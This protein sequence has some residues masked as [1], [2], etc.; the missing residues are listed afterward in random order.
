MVS[1]TTE[2]DVS[3]KPIPFTTILAVAFGFTFLILVRWQVDSVLP[4]LESFPIHSGNIGI[5]EVLLL[6][7]VQ[8]FTEWLPISSSGHLVI[9]QSLLD[10]RV[11]V[12]FDVMLHL[13]SLLSIIILLKDDLVA[14]IKP[15]MSLDFSD[16]YLKLL[17]YS[18]AGTIPVA[19]I[20]LLFKEFFESLFSNLT[21]TGLALLGN[22][23]ALYATRHCNG[24]KELDLIDSLVVGAAQSISI[25]P[26]ISRSGLTVSAAL[27]RGIRKDIAYRFSFLL[28][29]LAIL[30]ASIVKVGEIA[31]YQE[32]ILYFLLGLAISAITGLVA[33]KIVV[34]Y[35][36]RSE[37][38]RFAY[39]CWIV[40]AATTILG[41][42]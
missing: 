7:M 39:Y 8:G 31:S 15:A 40:G 19:V 4:R 24:E 18:I 35:V 30:G 3:P 14:M 10:I 29:I 42:F 11:S 28:S 17:G 6:A 12:A 38:Y 20:G 27:L 26:G 32:G 36:L 34:K 13:G 22:G 37:L 33:L 23:L 5:G 1:S 9:L 21:A 41:L 16:P 25:M 2:A